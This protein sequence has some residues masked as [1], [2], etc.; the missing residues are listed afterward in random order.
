MIIYKS[1][2]FSETGY[3]RYLGI[4]KGLIVYIGDEEPSGSIDIIDYSDSYIYPGFVDSHVH[5]MQ[6]GLS[7]LRCDLR[8]SESADDIYNRLISFAG[9]HMGLNNI[10]AEGFD[11]SAFSIPG[12]PVRQVIDEMFPDIPVIIRRICGHTAIINQKAELL[13]IGNEG[14]KESIY[15]NKTGIIK[16]GLI[17]HL[18]KVIFPDNNEI[19]N[20]YKSAE[21]NMFSHG[22]TAIGDISTDDSIEFYQNNTM[23][24]DIV[25]YLPAQSIPSINNE[26]KNNIKGIKLFL[27][28]SVGSMTAA[29]KRPYKNSKQNGKILL[30]HSDM[31]Q[32]VD[33]AE[34]HGLQ[35]AAH[36]I[37]D[38]AIAFALNYLR[39]GDRIEHF[40]FANDKLI[41]IVYKKGIRLSMQP[42]FVGNWGMKGQ[43]YENLLDPQYFTFNNSYE[44][45]VKRGIELGFG[46]DNMPIS[47]LYGILSAHRALF[48]NQRIDKKI[49][50]ELYTRGS[51]DI[52]DMTHFGILKCDYKAD[53]F[54]INKCIEEIDEHE[55][56][57]MLTVK[58][59]KMVYKRGKS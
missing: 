22:I 24:I 10:I 33:F 9:N 53:F 50:L 32:I 38:R 11:D 12:L 3:H 39:R 49:G 43:M 30:E 57:V 7:L 52:M 59:G 56:A 55:N 4:D 25:P 21:I 1:H 8:G 19:I 20:A 47:P 35:I 48:E 44:A 2:V 31:K 6:Y 45:I 34:K 54:I 37:G 28:G 58:N 15:D 29:F 42:N 46:S 14:F 41:D 18:D 26:I 17:L 13:F 27:D 36:A 16:E 5:M 51:S 40:E 23:Q